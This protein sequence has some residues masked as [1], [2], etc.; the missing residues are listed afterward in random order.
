MEPI[1][2]QAFR[3]ALPSK[4]DEQLRGILV[5]STDYLPEAVLAVR[6]ELRRRGT[7]EQEKEAVK[8]AILQIGR[9][10][11]VR[12]FERMFV[13][14]SPF[15][16]ICIFLFCPLLLA[17]LLS[18]S[19]SRGGYLLK[20]NQLW[21]CWLAGFALRAIFILLLVFAR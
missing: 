8:E 20:R 19:Y 18:Y 1:L 10:H 21:I 2:P 9:Q 4:S 14:L 13:P 12:V 3:D 16:R 6:D 11:A 15:A 17:F 7:L 5:N